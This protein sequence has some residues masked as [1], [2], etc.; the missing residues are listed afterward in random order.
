QGTSTDQDARFSNKQKKLLR[1]MKFPESFKKKV[2]MTKVNLDAL[3]PWIAGRVRELLGIEDE[4]VTEFV[5][6]LLAE[7]KL[8]P[9]HIQINL[10]G[11]LENNAGVFVQELWDMLLSAQENIGGIPA[12]LV[13]QKKQEIM[14]KQVSRHGDRLGAYYAY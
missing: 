10:T 4:V 11:F 12:K 5:F 8:D 14:R 1:T 6:G 2:N 3:R 13:E 7:E 9:R